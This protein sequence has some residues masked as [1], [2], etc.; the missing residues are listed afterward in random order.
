LCACGFGTKN[1]YTVKS[2]IEI[3]VPKYRKYLTLK[4]LSQN[5]N[6]SFGFHVECVNDH[7]L[8]MIYLPPRDVKVEERNRISA[9]L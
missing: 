9:I 4:K 6:F 5:F 2:E 3:T 8:T 1:I 7:M